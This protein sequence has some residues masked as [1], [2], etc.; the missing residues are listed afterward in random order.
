MT[1]RSANDTTTPARLVLDAYIIDPVTKLPMAPGVAS[2]GATETEQQ[3]QT[4]LLEDIRDAVALETTSQQMLTELSGQSTSLETL[5]SAAANTDPA[6]VFVQASEYE[7]IGASVTDEIAGST[8]AVGDIL[9]ALLVVPTSTT[10]GA[11]SIEDGT[12]NIQVYAGGT[13]GADLK[14]FAIP[15]FGIRSNAA[16][17]WEITTG[18]GCS[19]IAFGKFT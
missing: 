10:V 9:E 14:P 15:L 17:G 13:I 5:A 16:T 6:E 7:V 4:D 3:A 12:T 11:I 19:V 1:E 2:G 8:G 18:A